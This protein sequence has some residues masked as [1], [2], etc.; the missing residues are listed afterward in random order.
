MQYRILDQGEKSVMKK[1]KKVSWRVLM[2]QFDLSV[3][4]T[5]NNTVR[6]MLNSLHLSLLLKL[7]RKCPDIEVLLVNGHDIWNLLSQN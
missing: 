6:A 4:Y 3:D 1:K 5:L 7:L 2:G